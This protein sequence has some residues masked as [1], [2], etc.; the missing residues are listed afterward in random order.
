MWLRQQSREQVSTAKRRLLMTTRQRVQLWAE[1]RS[2][3]ILP[4]SHLPI[5]HLPIFHLAVQ[6]R[7]THLVHHTHH[8]A[9][10]L[11]LVRLNRVFIFQDLACQSEGQRPGLCTSGGRPPT[12]PSR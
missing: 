9:L 1:G 7:A 11:D 2:V 6:R 5:F 10:L 3:S 12:Y 4:S 8:K